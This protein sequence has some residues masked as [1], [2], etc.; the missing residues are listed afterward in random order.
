MRLSQKGEYGLLALL[1]LARRWGD[2]P[3]QASAIAR[4]RDIPTP[5]LQQ[6]LADLRR[7]GLVASERGP[8][9]GHAL[10]RSPAEITLLEAVEALEGDISPA[11][12]TGPGAGPG[13]PQRERCVLQEVWRRLDQ[14]ARAVLAGVTLESLARREEE[15]DG[16]PMYH[17]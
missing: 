4:Q 6:I 12:C 9:G 5:Y 10:S 8:R 17:I 14:S 3:L 7:A 1:E 11:P 15:R 16:A 13:C 2:R